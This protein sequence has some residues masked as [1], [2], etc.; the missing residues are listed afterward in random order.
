MMVAVIAQL[1]EN[2]VV[3]YILLAVMGRTRITSPFGGFATTCSNYLQELKIKCYNHSLMWQPVIY[4]RLDEVFLLLFSAFAFSVHGWIPDSRN[5]FIWLNSKTSITFN[6]KTPPTQPVFPVYF[7]GS[8]H[9]FIFFHQ[10]SN[11]AIKSISYLSLDLLNTL[12]LLFQHLYRNIDIIS[13]LCSSVVHWDCS[14][15]FYLNFILLSQILS[16]CEEVGIYEEFF[17]KQLLKDRL[18]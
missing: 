9:W 5:L 10:V 2:T 7:G 17:M 15:L 13:F 11:I 8:V 16:V 12:F 1:L 18:S 3:N 14:S 4:W 6:N